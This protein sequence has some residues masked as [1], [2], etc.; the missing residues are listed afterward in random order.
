MFAIIMPNFVKQQYQIVNKLASKIL[1]CLTV[2]TLA[3][4][5][6]LL[7]LKDNNI[8]PVAVGCRLVVVETTART[9]RVFPVVCGVIGLV[10]TLTYLSVG[11]TDY[12]YCGTLGRYAFSRVMSYLNRITTP[13]EVLRKV[14]MELEPLMA[15]SIDGHTHGKAAANRTS[16]SMT[17]E[18]LA[19]RLGLT[20]FFEQKSR[21]DERNG[22]FGSRTYFWF[23]DMAAKPSALRPEEGSMRVVVDVDYY[24]NMSTYLSTPFPTLLYTFSPTSVAKVTENYSYTFGFN[25]EVDYCVT[26]GGRY[27]HRVYN[28]S[29]DIMMGQYK[30]FGLPVRTTVYNVDRKRMDADHELVFFTPI[31]TFGV[32]GSI[33]SWILGTPVPTYLN[34]N[35]GGFNRLRIFGTD[36]VTVSTG[37]PGQF[38]SA[39]VSAQ[40]DDAIGNTARVQTSELSP[41][42]VEG[43]LSQDDKIIA[44]ANSVILAAFHRTNLT[45]GPIITLMLPLMPVVLI[46]FLF[47]RYCAADQVFPVA[48]AV[49][50]YQY[51]NF[52]PD[53]PHSLTAFMSPIVHESFAP[54]RTVGNER[55]AV[56]GRIDSVKSNASLTPM[57]HRLIEAFLVRYIPNPHQ[58]TPM[59]M[60]VVVEKQ[61]RPTQRKIIDESQSGILGWMRKI[62]FFIKA[63]SYAKPADPRIISTIN[64]RDKVEFSQFIYA[65]SE[66][67]KEQKWYFF[68]LTPR[69]IAVKV[70]QIC[71]NAIHFVCKTDMSRFD[72]HVSPVLR[73]FEE[74][75]MLRKFKQSYHPQLLDL[76]HSTKNL[77][78]V[79]MLGTRYEQDSVRASGVPDTSV[80][81]SE[82]NFFAAFV[83]FKCMKD[84]TGN[85]LSDDVAY[86]KAEKSGFGGDDGLV[87]DLCPIAHVKA[88][89]M[90]GLEIKT[91]P[92]Y[93]GQP[94]VVVLARCFSPNVWYGDINS[95]TDIARALSKLHVTKHLPPTCTPIDKLVEKCR[96]LALSDAQTPILGPFAR[97]VVQ[98]SE[99][100]VTHE[101]AVVL[102]TYLTYGIEKEEQFPQEDAM[103]MFDLLAE[104]IAD[105]DHDAFYRFLR[106]TRTLTDCLSPP[107]CVEPK[108]AKPQ[109]ARVYVDEQ[110][111]EPIEQKSPPKSRRRP[112]PESKALPKGPPKLDVAKPIEET[113]LPRITR[114]PKYDTTI[115]MSTQPEVRMIPKT[116]LQI[117]KMKR[118]GPQTLPHH[119][120]AK[121]IKRFG[122]RN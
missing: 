54:D 122:L 43:Y 112:K 38:S 98:L 92:V 119:I 102:N 81:N 36:S 50:H 5:P 56:K 80:R 44:K 17:A 109:A 117:A 34:L 66:F 111:L 63:E 46:R 88:C 59:D 75:S 16:S 45:P 96:S 27:R 49:R 74:R 31:A 114:Q 107:M 82:D 65:E 70:S 72:G 55:Q 47:P 22:R 103:W 89:K 23:K 104:Q 86:A 113:P 84:E 58:L 2:Q 87:A 68:G 121:A 26:G 8:E 95:C 79:G 100:Y 57:L 51:G 29:S 19:G 20:P 78:A 41:N 35:V 18:L 106:N 116:P 77:N 110:I 3:I 48:Q 94:G 118:D 64:G 73:V 28:Y 60:D 30:L 71:M 7:N 21:A 9:S 32:L 115:V 37:F 33:L 13:P 67:L 15:P 25:N 10:V 4:V 62:K 105:F 11:T 14:F 99:G 83:G 90:L 97:R 12:Y 24:M 93:F 61:N 42:S 40:V 39:T 6:K 69:K 52:E 108:P 91:E 53:A 76:I 101:S 120:P 1:A 85:F